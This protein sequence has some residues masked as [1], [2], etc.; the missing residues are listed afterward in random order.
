[1]K[2]DIEAGRGRLTTGKKLAWS[3]GSFA[4]QFMTNGIGTLANPIYNIGLGVDPRLLGWALGIPR[5]W[6]AVTDPF[7]GN[8]SDN[9][10]SRWGRRRPYIFA[11]AILSGV[12][13]ALAWMPPRSW[14]PAAI[15]AFFFAAS[16]VYYLFYTIFA[17]P[18]GAMGL[19]MSYDPAERTRIQ[20]WKMVVGSVAG[21]VM[22]AMWW[23]SV[24]IGNGD[25]VLGVRYVGVISGI[26][27]IVT[28]IIPVFACRESAAVQAQ[29]QIRFLHAFRETFANRHFV[30]LV[31]AYLCILLGIFLTNA[32]SM[33]ITLYYLYGGNEE[34]ASRLN[35]VAN[36]TYQGTGLAFTPVVACVAA[37]IGKRRTLLIGLGLVMFSYAT[38]W[39]LF[40][41][42]A[43]YLQLVSLVLASPGLASAWIL[44]SS[45]IADLCDVDELRTG[46]R[47]EGMYGSAYGWLVKTGLSGTL[48]LSGYMLTWSGFD[49][50]AGGTQPPDV[51]LNM[52]L[53][54][55]LVPILFLGIAALLM[56][57]YPITE[58]YVR[59][60]RAEIDARKAARALEPEPETVGAGA[61]A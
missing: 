56:W 42:K 24:R 29:P 26:L 30:T 2:E 1:M 17:V 44:G 11:G 47:R 38:S 45:M 48:V 36:W 55:A 6:D 18:W 61:G 32:F 3:A 58:A 12:I 19:E 5:L 34:A 22:G 27:I 16:L 52:R 21:L 37:R 33:Y 4:D 50:R 60:I 13:F 15:G 9:T 41:P 23:M 8:I 28:G 40:T 43:P 25:A 10:R 49:A 46:L 35:M 20:A 31:I 51:I 7:M 54:Y 59:G 14:S 39:F 57:R 53:L